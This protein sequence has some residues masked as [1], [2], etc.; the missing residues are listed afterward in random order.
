MLGL[1]E[2]KDDDALDSEIEKLIQERQKARAEK[3]YVIADDIRGNLLKRGIVLEDT[4][5]G[6]K[7][8][9]V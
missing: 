7:W 4:P 5:S 2:K 1:L 6:V 3:N 9:R 8:R